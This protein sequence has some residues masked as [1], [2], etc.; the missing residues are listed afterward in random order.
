[1]NIFAV[2]LKYVKH[3][4]VFFLKENPLRDKWPIE[5]ALISGFCSVKRI[6]VLSLT[7]HGWDTNPP[8]VSSQQRLVL[9]CLPRKDGKLSYLRRKSKAN[10]N[11]YHSKA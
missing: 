10:K 1:M 9:I 5:P 11:S 6:S 7:L 2:V 8:Q 4:P 3:V